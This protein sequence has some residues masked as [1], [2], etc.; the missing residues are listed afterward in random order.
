[1]TVAVSVTDVPTVT[2]VL[3]TPRAVL[4]EVV[5]VLAVTVIVRALEVLA[6]YELA[7]A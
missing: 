3:D 6:V 7:P 1:V 2:E 5:P 4:V